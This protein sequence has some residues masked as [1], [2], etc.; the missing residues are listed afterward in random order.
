[1]Q[2]EGLS[3]LSKLS[4]FHIA[5]LA[6]PADVAFF[7]CWASITLSAK[8]PKADQDWGSALLTWRPQ[9]LHHPRASLSSSGESLF[10]IPATHSWSLMAKKHPSQ[11][12]FYLWLQGE[13]I[14]RNTIMCHSELNRPLLSVQSVP[15]A[16]R[17]AV[18]SAPQAFPH[19]LLT[20]D[21]ISSMW[22][23]G[24]KDSVM[25]LPGRGWEALAQGNLRE[26]SKKAAMPG[27]RKEN[28]VFLPFP[29]HH[30]HSSVQSQKAA[31][32]KS[33][34]KQAFSSVS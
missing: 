19:Q 27:T 15:R 4:L 17:S 25:A 29:S 21:A 2:A 10:F 34:R 23:H 6:L 14:V 12:P 9:S 20:A 13:K 24:E 1:M 5:M 32:T 8:L 7:T 18:D 28:S 22:K 3:Q 16:P 26:Q 11:P 31:F 30:Q 33:L